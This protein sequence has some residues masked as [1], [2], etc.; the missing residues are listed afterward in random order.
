MGRWLAGLVGVCAVLV[1]CGGPVER[2]RVLSIFFDGVPKP[3]DAG[4]VGPDAGAGAAQPE[5]ELA[6]STH[7][8][9]AERRCEG[10]HDP[11]RVL[12]PAMELALC[13]RCHQ[14][15]AIMFARPHEPVEDEDCAACHLPH[16]SG[17]PH[18]LRRRPQKLCR[19]CH[20]PSREPFA[21]VHA[22]LGDELPCTE[23]HHAHGGDEAAFLKGGEAPG[24]LCQRCHEA[25]PAAEEG[26]VPRMAHA[27]FEQGRCRD[28]HGSH[29][30]PGMHLKAESFDALCLSCHD[31]A[32]VIPARPHEPVEDEDCAACHVP[33]ESTEARLLRKPPQKL[34]RPCHSPTKEAFATVHAPLGDELPCTEWRWRRSAVAVTAHVPLADIG[35]AAQRAGRAAS[36]PGCRRDTHRWCRSRSRPSPRRSVARDSCGSRLRR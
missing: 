4:S 22:P 35:V 2:Y 10:C 16:E 21:K 8:P 13:L 34:C 6:G 14:R 18:L 32:T 12:P 27:P 17:E 26:A 29:R 36:R 7:R 15:D 25:A 3:P 11:Q 1:A 28:C 19:P 5:V 30:T 33:H 20:S 24:P 9:Y 31:R 23:C